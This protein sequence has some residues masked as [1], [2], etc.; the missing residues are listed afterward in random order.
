MFENNFQGI[1]K[2]E[3]I[4]QE[5]ETPSRNINIDTLIDQLLE[6]LAI[7]LRKNLE[8]INLELNNLDVEDLDA[9]EAVERLLVLMEQRIIITIDFVNG[10]KDTEYGKSADGLDVIKQFESMAINFNEIKQIKEGGRELGR[11]QAGIVY[12]HDKFNDCVKFVYSLNAYKRSN[13]IENELRIQRLLMDL[14]VNGVR[15]PEIMNYFTE[16]KFHVIQM[17]KLNAVSLKDIGEGRADLPASFHLEQFFIDLKAYID[18]MNAIGIFHQDLHEGNIMID[19]ETGKPRVI[20]FGKSC[21]ASETKAINETIRQRMIDGMKA[22][23]ESNMIESR[24]FIQG[25]L[26]SR[27]HYAK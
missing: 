22:N 27:K 7:N 20:D 14:E 12:A 17:E 11:G 4:D 6:E 18:A 10:I 9:P 13:T 16:G 15:C 8:G 19:I 2:R 5:K 24:R 25:H 23:D 3:L 1:K 21:V 26:N